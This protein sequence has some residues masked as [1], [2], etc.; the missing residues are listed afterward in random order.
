MKFSNLKTYSNS[1]PWPYEKSPWN[2]HKWPSKIGRFCGDPRKYSQFH[3]TQK[4][5]HFSE[6]HK[7]YI[8]IQKFE[9]SLRLPIYEN[10]KV[11][12]GNPLG[13]Q[14]DDCETRTDAEYL[15]RDLGAAGSNLT[16]VTVLC[17]WWR[18]IYPC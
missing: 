12:P 13:P 18:H 3:H 16:C 5:N 8:E 2:I 15:T 17:P 7:L 10:I 11:P 14:Q 1:V 6:K 4:N 9:K